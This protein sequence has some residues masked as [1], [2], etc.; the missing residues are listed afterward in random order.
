MINGGDDNHI[1]RDNSGRTYNPASEMVQGPPQI[2]TE[3]G[4]DLQGHRLTQ[5]DHKLRSVYGDHVHRNDGTH[6]TGGIADDALWHTRWHRISNLTPR[7][8]DAPKG[9]AGRHFVILLTEELRG[10]KELRWNSER[11]NYH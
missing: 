1:I 5:C 3:A 8:Y 2:S 11:P 6:L 7:F 4:A 10:A 9:K